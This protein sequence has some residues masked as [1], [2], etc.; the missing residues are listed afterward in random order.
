MR[1]LFSQ[2][3]PPSSR[4]PV[5]GYKIFHNYTGNSMETMTSDTQHIVEFTVPGVYL[6]T[7]MAYNVLGDGKQSTIVVTG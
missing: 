3:P 4:P 5:I 7:V 2:P 6:F 1:L